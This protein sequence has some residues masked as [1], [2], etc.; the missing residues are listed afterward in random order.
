MTTASNS[1]EQSP[2]QSILEFLN[3]FRIDRPVSFYLGLFS[4]LTFPIFLVL[5]SVDD[6]IVG[7]VNTWIK[8]TKFSISIWIYLWTMGIILNLLK[9]E[10]KFVNRAEIVVVISMI[11]ELV[12]ISIQAGRGVHSHY[13][14]ST[15]L[16]SGIYKAMGVFAFAQIPVAIL[17]QKKFKTSANDISSDLRTAIRI[18][19]WLFVFACI[20][21][22][23]MSGREAH[24][25]GVPDGGPGIPFM[26]WSVN[27]G[28]LRI[29]HFFG[30]HSLQIIPIFSLVAKKWNLG[31]KSVTIFAILFGSL[32]VSMF[33]LAL[34]GVSI[35]YKM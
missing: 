20:V 9:S 30:I 10:T 35:F 12:L 1:A 25:V 32:N 8:P 31:N 15:L 19:L 28:D 23:T 13:N 17:I 34:L 21:G 18:A 29:A 3:T 22:G 11:M 2:F 5:L 6:R 14:E 26:N 16:D 24:S 33:V 4:V 27:G 7:G